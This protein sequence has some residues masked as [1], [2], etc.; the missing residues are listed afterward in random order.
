MRKPMLVIALLI[1]IMWAVPAEAQAHQSGWQSNREASWYGGSFIGN[2]TSCGQTYRTSSWW[3]SSFKTNYMH[4]GLKV[5]ICKAG[6]TRCVNVRVQDRGAV[7]T[8]RRDFDL[9]VRVRD[10]LRCNTCAIRWR[11]GWQ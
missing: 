5:R 2:R 11:T 6:T 4:C 7:H 10:A 8:G 9:T 3:V 1:S